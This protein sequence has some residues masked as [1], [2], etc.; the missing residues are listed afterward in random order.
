MTQALP[1]GEFEYVNIGEAN[2]PQIGHVSLEKNCGRSDNEISYPVDV[3]LVF[4][5]SFRNK[6]R[7]FAISTDSKK[8]DRVFH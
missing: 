5:V 6:T 3:D 4:K 7:F 2:C 1:Y 8:I